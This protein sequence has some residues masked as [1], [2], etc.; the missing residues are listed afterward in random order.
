[1]FARY[2]YVAPLGLGTPVVFGTISSSF[3]E[4]AESEKNTNRKTGTKLDAP[5]P[6]FVS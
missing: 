3:Y 1:M 5:F 4:D 6:F 2:K